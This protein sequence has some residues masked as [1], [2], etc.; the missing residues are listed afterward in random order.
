MRAHLHHHRSSPTPQWE[1][2]T[3]SSSHHVA[4]A[5]IQHSAFASHIW[6]CRHATIAAN[7]QK[8]LPS[9]DLC[10]QSYSVTLWFDLPL[11]LQSPCH[12]P[13]IGGVPVADQNVT[14]AAWEIALSACQKAYFGCGPR[15]GFGSLRTNK[16]G[17]DL[18]WIYFTDFPLYFN[19]SFCFLLESVFH[20]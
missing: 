5:S 10:R 18:I 6:H 7:T 12:C 3:G 9:R 15:S 17:S 1:R 11:L 4:V 20:W 19:L 14:A 2:I 13:K 16:S 8:L